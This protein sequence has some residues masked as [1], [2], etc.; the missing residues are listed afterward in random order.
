MSCNDQSSQVAITS[1]RSF[2]NKLPPAKNFSQSPIENKID[3]AASPLTMFLS[4]FRQTLLKNQIIF[5][6]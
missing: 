1:R 2:E 4:L 5:F 6:L 3:H